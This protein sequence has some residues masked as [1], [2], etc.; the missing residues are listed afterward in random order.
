[1]ASPV[2]ADGARLPLRSGSVAALTA[3]AVLH[4]FDDPAAAVA[5][6]ARALAPGGRCH[7]TDGVAMSPAEAAAMN[8]ELTDAGL[9]GEP[10]GGID[11]DHLVEACVRAGLTIV[12]VEVVGRAVFASPPHVSRVYSTDRFEVVAER[13]V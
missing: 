12:S 2:C 1:M 5:E 7:L 8:A 13:P 4:H 9:P 11:L 6:F 10:R 3:R